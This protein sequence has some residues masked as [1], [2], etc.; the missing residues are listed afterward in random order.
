MRNFDSGATRNTDEDKY[1]YE[2]FMNPLVIEA[3]GEYMHKNRIQADGKLRPSDN[4]QKGIPKEAYMKS[5]WRHFHDW[6]MEHRGYKSREGKIDAL[7]GLLFNT[8]G[9]LYE[10]LKEK[11]HDT[12]TKV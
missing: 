8:M 9:Y 5:A 2:G 3:F 11:P 1:D 6:W 7:C 10:E 12:K 4:W